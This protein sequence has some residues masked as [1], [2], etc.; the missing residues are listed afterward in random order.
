MSQISSEG[1]PMS[2]P[3]IE[4]R[5]HIETIIGD[6]SPSSNLKHILPRIAD[7][8]RLKL[9][10]FSASRIA[11]MWSKD[12]RAIRSDEM[13]L[14]RAEARRAKDLRQATEFDGAANALLALGKDCDRATIDRL[15]Q[16]ARELRGQDP[17]QDRS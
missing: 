6:I 4:A 16:L 9:K 8:L 12:A 13:D 11:K 17:Q 14:L 15:R 1:S 7:A 3:R 10:S 5:T 2:C